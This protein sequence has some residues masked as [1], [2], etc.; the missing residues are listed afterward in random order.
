[1]GNQL[2]DAFAHAKF[3]K[4]YAKEKRKTRQTVVNYLF[5]FVENTVYNSLTKFSCFFC[6]QNEGSQLNDAFA[7]AKSAKLYAKEKR[8][9]RH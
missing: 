4:L 7:H 2:N 9:T 6:I 5:L 1:M 3:A 8:K